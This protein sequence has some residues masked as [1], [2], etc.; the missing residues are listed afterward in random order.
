MEFLLRVRHCSRSGEHSS[1]QTE[2]IPC[3][4]FAA[5]LGGKSF[6][7]VHFTFEENEAQRG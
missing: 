1:D 7:F 2:L 3:V 6:N 5:L 4:P